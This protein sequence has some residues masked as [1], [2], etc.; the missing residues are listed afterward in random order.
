VTMLI[1]ASKREES[2]FRI[3]T[4]ITTKNMHIETGAMILTISSPRESMML[5]QGL[6]VWVC[7]IAR[8]EKEKERKTVTLTQIETGDWEVL[9]FA[10]WIHFSHGPGRNI[11]KKPFL[12]AS[13]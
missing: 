3:D 4:N 13:P 9:W 7:A 1:D 12:S 11:T 5:E 10:G 6:W 2:V 8:F